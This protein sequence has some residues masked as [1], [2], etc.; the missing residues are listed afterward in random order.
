MKNVKKKH[1]SRLP[2]NDDMVKV[3]VWVH[4]S[5]SFMHM[6]LCSVAEGESQTWQEEYAAGKEAHSNVYDIV[7]Q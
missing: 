2:S 5:K 1:S 4:R 7:N 6:Y 3:K